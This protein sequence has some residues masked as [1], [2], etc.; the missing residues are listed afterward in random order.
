MRESSP[1]LAHAFAEGATSQGADV[2]AAGLGSTDLLYYAS[3]ALDLPG[4]MFTA[5]HNPA[6]YNGIKLCRAGARP[7]GQETGLAEIR[8]RA[9]AILAGVAAAGAG[10]GAV[11]RCDL[12]TEY[13]AHLRTLVDLSKIRP[14]RVVVDAGNG[15]GGYTVPAVLGDAALDPL[16]LE[17]VP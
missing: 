11:E 7:I 8:E 9:E 15:M 2:V 14:L 1:G 6:R 17:I 13:A 3:G 10:T 16:P 5:S 12:L 4:A